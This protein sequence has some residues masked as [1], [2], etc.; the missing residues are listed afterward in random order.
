MRVY[1]IDNRCM[2]KIGDV[3]DSLRRRFGSKKVDQ[4]DNY[5]KR[6]AGLMDGNSFYIFKIDYDKFI[7]G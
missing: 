5:I 7:S 6:K 3:R 1:K 2:L 4:F